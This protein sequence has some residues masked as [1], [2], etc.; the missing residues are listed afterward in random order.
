[1]SRLVTVEAESRS[2]GD[3]LFDIHGK[4]CGIEKD[5]KHVMR[6]IEKNDSGSRSS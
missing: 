5:I 6:K 1:M 3:I 4:V 2:H